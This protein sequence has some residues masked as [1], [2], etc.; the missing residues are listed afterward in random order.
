LHKEYVLQKFRKKEG[1]AILIKSYPQRRQS[2]FEKERSLINGA[3]DLGK[4]EN[5]DHNYSI[6]RLHRLL[7]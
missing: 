3:K 6:F 2:I 5:D 4:K 1:N 7:F